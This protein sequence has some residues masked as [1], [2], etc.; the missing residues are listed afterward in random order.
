MERKRLFRLWY[1]GD[2]YSDAL[3][4]ERW[5]PEDAG[6]LFESRR[7]GA[8][9]WAFRWFL[10]ILGYGE[11]PWVFLGLSAVVIVVCSFLLMFFGFAYGTTTI[12]REFAF[13]PSE[14]GPT[15]NDWGLSLYFSIVTF[16]TVGYGDATPIG[17]TRTIAAAEALCGVFFYSAFI[18]TYLKRLSDE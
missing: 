12:Q 5:S 4:L 6:K 18:A 16:T 9:Q 2:R 14:F 13:A 11:N 15:L 7:M 1:H 8:M 17:A 10:T 3:A